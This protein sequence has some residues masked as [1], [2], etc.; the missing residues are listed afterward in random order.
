MEFEAQKSTCILQVSR[1]VGLESHLNPVNL[2]VQPD[3]LCEWKRK[4]NSQV[5]EFFIWTTK[6]Y[7]LI[8]L[9]ITTII[10]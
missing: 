4:Q 8:L 1:I 7:V 2:T 6:A 10:K 5:S 3:V 9:I